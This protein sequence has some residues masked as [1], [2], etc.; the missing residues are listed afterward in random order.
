MDRKFCQDEERFVSLPSLMYVHTRSLLLFEFQDCKRSW[1]QFT[2][3]R[4]MTLPTAQ[5]LWLLKRPFLCIVATIL[6]PQR[7]ALTPSYSTA[8]FYLKKKKNP[9]HTEGY[10]RLTDEI[11][12][13]I[14]E[15]G[16]SVLENT[17]KLKAT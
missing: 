9:Q 4:R 10:V 2:P 3:C 6:Q 7:R 17:F 8:Q 5:K 13:A 11:E 15:V 1:K 14:F 12:D 16:R